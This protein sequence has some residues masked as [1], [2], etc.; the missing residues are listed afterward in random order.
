MKPDK[1]YICHH[2]TLTLSVR[3]TARAGTFKAR[4]VGRKPADV[5]QHALVIRPGTVLTLRKGKRETRF[6]QVQAFA[7]KLQYGGR[8]VASGVIVATA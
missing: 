4:V 6:V 1:K 2:G 3:E 7:P 8:M 5:F